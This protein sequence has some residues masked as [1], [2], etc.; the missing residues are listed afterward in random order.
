MQAVKE[1]DSLI[2]IA[3]WSNAGIVQ[4]TALSNLQNLIAID[5]NRNYI[6]VVD[7]K[8]QYTE[9]LKIAEDYCRDIL[10]NHSE[11]Y[12][13]G[14]VQSTHY[15]QTVKQLLMQLQEPTP[16]ATKINLVCQC[17]ATYQNPEEVFEML[18]REGYSWI[19]YYF[20]EL[21]LDR[22][23]ANGY[24]T[25]KMSQEIYQIQQMNLVVR[26]IRDKLTPGQAYS[27]R[28]V[29]TVLQSIYDELGIKATATATEL[30]RYCP[31][32]QKK[33]VKGTA[34]YTIM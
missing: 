30:T 1:Q 13:I 8:P 27:S 28:D 11:W 3:L 12:V 4:E 10:V 17:M 20:H 31:E 7:G 2:Q 34:Y 16:M 21:P 5:P 32:C 29:K 19:G 26:K 15:S 18:F 24:N 33:M 22:I 6:R 23:I 25:T 14:S 9:L